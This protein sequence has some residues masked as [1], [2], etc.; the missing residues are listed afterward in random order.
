MLKKIKATHPPKDIL[1]DEMIKDNKGYN[2][3]LI[4]KTQK[5]WIKFHPARLSDK[6]T[7]C[8]MLRCTEASLLLILWTDA[9]TCT[10]RWDHQ[11]DAKSEAE[12]QLSGLIPN[13][14]SETITVTNPIQLYQPRAYKILFVCLYLYY[15][16]EEI[17]A[18][19]E[20]LA[21]HKLRY[22]GP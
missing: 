11:D 9:L 13:P 2:K 10:V 4:S 14:F 22:L 12:M 3:C 20:N 21:Q 5:R 18:P 19:V 17:C 8:W 6:I 16:L 7:V 1:K 15:N